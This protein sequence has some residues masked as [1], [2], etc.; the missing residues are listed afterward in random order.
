MGKGE[1]YYR[2]VRGSAAIGTTRLAAGEVA[3]EA[4]APGELRRVPFRG[5]LLGAARI[6]AGFAAIPLVAFDRAGER[7]EA[8]AQAAWLQLVRLSW[9]EGRNWARVA[10]KELMARLRLSERR[11]LRV[12]DA[13]V[14]GGFASPLHRDNRGTLWLVA[15]PG[16][17]FGE[18]PGDE[19]LLG[20][21]SQGAAGAAPPDGL[22]LAPA[23]ARAEPVPA[24]TRPVRAGRTPARRN[25]RE[26]QLARALLE[27]R[28]LEG[29]AA[30]AAAL[31]EVQELVDEGQ[32]HERIAAAIAAVARRTAGGGT[33]AP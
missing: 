12:L 20:R 5:H 13:L 31:R 10:K 11:L 14:T 28:G 24:A 2:G 26:L 23:V 1:A 21:A 16:E 8:E 22:A 19:V 9:S 30:E 15:W 4:L 25:A 6:R 17:P 27:A 18:P 33:E 29:A 7:L 3:A 32:G